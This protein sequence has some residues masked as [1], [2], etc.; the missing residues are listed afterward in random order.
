MRSP[1]TCWIASQ[2]PASKWRLAARAH[3]G[4]RRSG[5]RKPSSSTRAIAARVVGYSAVVAAVTIGV[6]W[7][8][9][10]RDVARCV[11]EKR[12]RQDPRVLQRR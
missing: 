3:R 2:L 11:A 6:T 5:G 1:A 4:T 10:R 9:V 7:H 8:A 12:Q